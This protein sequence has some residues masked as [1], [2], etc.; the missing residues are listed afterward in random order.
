MNISELALRRPVLATVMNLLIILFGAVGYTF[1]AVR[2][3]PAVDPPIINVRTSYA[4]ANSD[5]IESQITEPLEKSINGIQGIRNISSSSSVGSSNITVEFNL[6]ADLEAAANDV[7][8]KVSQ[9]I[10]SL[11]QDLDAPPVVSKSDV[12]GDFII[13]LAV[14]SESKSLLELSDYTENVLQQRFQTIPEV[15]AVNIFGQKRPSMRIWFDPNKLNAYN[16]TFSDV[17][18]VLNRENVEIPSGKIYGDKTEMVIRA[19][20]RLST[21]KD[22]SDLISRE[23]ANGIVRLSDVA[24]VEIGPENEEFSWRLNGVNA[25]GIAIIPQP[26]ANYIKIADEF[27]KRLSVPKTVFQNKREKEKSQQEEQK[28]KEECTFKPQIDKKKEA[29]VERE[30][31]STRLFKLA[32]QLKEKREK[33]KREQ[34]EAQ[35][36]SCTFTPN[37]DETSK[38]LMLKYGNTPLY[39]RVNI[40]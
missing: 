19:I 4:G 25:V 30:Q 38:Q 24:K 21:E 15:S 37:I 14:Q 26:G 3:Y 35:L 32:E 27:Y 31:V 7:R 28:F 36:N 9:A 40:C 16:V 23:D 13:L 10:R 1:L 6:D 33:L 17:R 34:H 39:N 12:G 8:D 18:N 5:I 11:P 2:E 22:F 29:S 20:G